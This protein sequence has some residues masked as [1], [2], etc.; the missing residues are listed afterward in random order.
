MNP[1]DKLYCVNDITDFN[2]MN[3]C[4]RII[5]YH[6]NIYEILSVD[7]HHGNTNYYSNIDYYIKSDIDCNTYIFRETR[8][9]G[10]I[11]NSLISK[12]FITIKE[13]RKLKINNICS[14]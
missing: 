9:K 8:Y 6:D 1:G 10:K 14:K 4:N 3:S 12:H 5:F 11:L 7:I 13:S 2:F